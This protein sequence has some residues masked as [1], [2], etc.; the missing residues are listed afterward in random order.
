MTTCRTAR[1]FSAIATNCVNVGFRSLQI[2]HEVGIW[3]NMDGAASM[4]SSTACQDRMWIMLSAT[5]LRSSVDDA[6][7]GTSAG[8]LDDDNVPIDFDKAATKIQSWW[9]GTLWRRKLI[10]TRAAFRDLV[11]EV[12]GHDSAENLSFGSSLVSP[13][14]NASAR[15][16]I[17]GFVLLW[18][19]VWVSV[20]FKII[21]F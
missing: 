14:W 17:S 8:I 2:E 9:R 3:S 13:P 12:E 4:S 15:W 1:E 16:V 10:S 20:R 19:G 18:L 7:I 11:M 6:P 21:H 5:V